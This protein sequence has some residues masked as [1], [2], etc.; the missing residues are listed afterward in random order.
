MMTQLLALLRTLGP[1][2]GPR[3]TLLVD[4]YRYLPLCLRSSWASSRKP[5]APSTACTVASTSCATTASKACD[6]LRPRLAL[7]LVRLAADLVGRAT[8][9]QPPQHLPQAAAR[10]IA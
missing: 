6:L 8:G 7:P 1:L 10:K 4:A 5:L 3:R 9:E 2:A